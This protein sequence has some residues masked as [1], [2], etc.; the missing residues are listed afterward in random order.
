MLYDRDHQIGHSYFLNINNVEGL[1][2][3]WYYEIIPLLQEYFYGDWTK[4]SEIIGSGFVE[5]ITSTNIINN[6]IND[7]DRRIYK[8]KKMMTTQPS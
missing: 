8:I 5:E 3:T 7:P 6:E 2:S 4:L 1:R